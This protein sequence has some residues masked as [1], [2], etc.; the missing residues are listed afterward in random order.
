MNEL[1]RK[2]GRYSVAKSVMLCVPSLG[3]P[4]FEIR[5]SATKAGHQQQLTRKL[6]VNVNYPYPDQLTYAL[7][8]EHVMR[9][10]LQKKVDDYVDAALNLNLETTAKQHAKER[11][12]KEALERSNLRLA[13]VKRDVAGVWARYGPELDINKPFFIFQWGG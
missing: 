10:T 8:Q 7:D 12:S 11:R 13:T 1:P 4:F 5:V 9:V 3:K 2:P 6:Y